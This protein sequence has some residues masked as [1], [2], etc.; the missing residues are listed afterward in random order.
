MKIELNSEHSDLLTIPEN[1]EPI[2]LNCISIPLLIDGVEDLIVL[3]VG[4]SGAAK[5]VNYL[6]R[7][8]G[9]PPSVPLLTPEQVIAVAQQLAELIR[10][11]GARYDLVEK[12]NQ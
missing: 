11:H 4:Q 3:Y 2:I 12:R 8:E 7:Q 1:I 9:K 10:H 6:D 5:I